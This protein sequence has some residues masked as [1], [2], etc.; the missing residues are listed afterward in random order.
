M[1][2]AQ[3]KSRS[4]KRTKKKRAKGVVIKYK[5]KRAEKSKCE[6]GSLLSGIRKSGAKSEKK[7]S[8]KYGGRLCPKCLRKLVLTKATGAK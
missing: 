4:W 7:V 1:T 3:Y 8:R 5:R 6:C 2:K